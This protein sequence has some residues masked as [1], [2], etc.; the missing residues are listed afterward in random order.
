[1]GDQY[2]SVEHLVIAIATRPRPGGHR[3]CERPGSPPKPCSAPWRRCGAAGPVTSQD[4][5]DTLDALEKFGR[6]LTALAA[7]GKLD[8]VIGRDDEIR[9]VIQVLSRRTKNNPLLIG[10]PGVGK[11]AIAEGLAG[12][13]VDGDVPTGLENK[14][15]VALDL[16]SMVAGAKYRG[17]FEE[18][19]KAVLDEIK[20][21]EGG[22]ITFLDEMHTL[23]GAGAAEGAMDAS[24]MLKPMLARGEL[25]MIGATTLDEYRKHIEKD[26]ALERR[27]QPVMVEPAVGRGHHRHPARAQGALRGA[28]R[29][30][31]PRLG[32][33]GRRRPVR[34]L[35][36]RPPPARQGDRPDRRGG[37]A[38]ADRDRLDARGDR[39]AGAP[40]P[41]ARDRAQRP[42]QGERPRLGGTTRGGRAAARRGRRGA[43]GAAGRAG[44]SKRDQIDA[45]RS[46]QAGDRGRPRRVGAGRAHRRPAAC[47]RAALRHA[48]QAGGA[49]WP[50]T[51]RRW[52]SSRSDGRHAQGGGRARRTS[53]RW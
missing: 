17:E 29:S 10:E 39:R 23:V 25:R 16:G 28:P 27:F 7:A 43:A 50:S 3:P 30:A 19:L 40:A 52:P 33:G 9:R 36:H 31:H 11:T 42:R 22:I 20:A 34:P 15:I 51:T 53:P 26:A 4:P 45:I 32:A 21:A 46:R 18:R 6:D 47:R 1:M 49:N 35:H 2:V 13:I 48:A 14:R 38:P 41:P 8:P 44:S 5:E 37:L 12:R 24:N